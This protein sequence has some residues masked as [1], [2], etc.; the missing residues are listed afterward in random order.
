MFVFFKNDTLKISN[1]LSTNLS[2]YL[3]VKFAFICFLKKES[4]FYTGIE[5]RT[6]EGWKLVA[7]EKKLGR[8]IFIIE[9]KTQ[10]KIGQNERKIYT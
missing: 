3:P 9:N 4:I 2:S 7:F 5:I 10:W 8:N 6:G 1:T